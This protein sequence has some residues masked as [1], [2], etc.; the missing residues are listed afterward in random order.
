MQERHVKVMKLTVGKGV[1][2]KDSTP[3][4]A[5]TIHAVNAKGWNVPFP[6]SMASL[7]SLLVNDV[8]TEISIIDDRNQKLTLTK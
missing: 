3:Y 1:L 5:E 4:A 6:Y 7:C 8:Y 2:G